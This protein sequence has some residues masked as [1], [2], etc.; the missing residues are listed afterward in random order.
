[1]LNERRAVHLDQVGLSAFEKNGRVSLLRSEAD[2]DLLKI[3]YQ[4]VSSSMPNPLC[5]A[6]FETRGIVVAYRFPKKFLNEWPRVHGK[7]VRLI[8]GFSK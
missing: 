5:Y 8:D 6:E 3:E 2:A 1:M 4:E 7:V